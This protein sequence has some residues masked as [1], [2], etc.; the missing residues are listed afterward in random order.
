MSLDIL[1]DGIIFDRYPH[2]GIARFFF[3]VISRIVKR[4]YNIR[5]FVRC[6]DRGLPYLPAHEGI[7][8]LVFRE[9][10]FR[11]SRICSKVNAWKRKQ[12]DARI[13][14][15]A[16][17]IFHSTYYSLPSIDGVKTVATVY[18]LIDYEYPLFS[19]NGPGFVE[20]QKEVLVHA[21]RVI[22]IS[23]STAEAAIEAFEL[24]RDRVKITY[25]GAS[26]TFFPISEAEKKHFRDKYTSGRPY[27]LFVGSTSSYKNLGT[28]IR[29][30]AKTRVRKDYCLLIAGHS[31]HGVD[32]WY[33]DS[34][35][36]ESVERDIVLLR[37]PRDDVLRLAYGAAEAF[38]F[39]SLQE[40]FG[41]P[42]LEA[43]K[44]G[45][46]V[47]ASDILVFHEVCGD[48]AL[49]FD[50]HNP[51]ALA[52]SLIE[53]GTPAIAQELIEKGFERAKRFSWDQAAEEMERIYIE[54]SAE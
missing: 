27:F 28:V 12:L 8:P 17:S 40:G 45:T 36:S 31:V 25:L 33:W 22:S 21:D 29:A 54:L 20:R 14:N 35:I 42:L 5:F 10:S 3:E 51:S 30:M 4:N 18:D 32:S 46:P 9:S 44:C 38:V 11:P 7:V 24:S 16:P 6:E 1:I 34:A 15:I 47:V 19:P 26:D 53:A 23:N 43:M 48:A 50:P 39:S 49:F 2:G 13:R 37:C 41:I 52:D